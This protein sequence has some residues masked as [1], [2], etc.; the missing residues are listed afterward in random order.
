MGRKKEGH[1]Q[2]P[3]VGEPT[4]IPIGVQLPTPLGAQQYLA[5][6]TP[7]FG[8]DLIRA[9]ITENAADQPGGTEAKGKPDRHR[10]SPHKVLPLQGLTSNQTQFW[11]P[12]C[13]EG[14]KSGPAQCCGENFTEENSSTY[15]ST[16]ETPS[17]SLQ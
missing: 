12:G 9:E 15:E 2:N 14:S 5:K 3:T 13:L 16:V 7:G 8:T 11:C 4:D 1:G 10:S 6:D 17:P